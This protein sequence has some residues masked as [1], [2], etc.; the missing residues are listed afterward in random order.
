MNKSVGRNLGKLTNLVYKQTDKAIFKSK[1]KKIR[2]LNKKLGTLQRVVDEDIYK[3]ILENLN[4]PSS[5]F[6]T[7][8]GKIT[9]SKKLWDSVDKKELQSLLAKTDTLLDVKELKQ[10]AKETLKNSGVLKSMKDEYKE[11]T[12]KLNELYEKG[13]FDEETLKIFQK[14][15]KKDYNKRVN[16]AVK[17]EVNA[18]FRVD[19]NID[20]AIQD[21]YDF[22]KSYGSMLASEYPEIIELDKFIY[23]EGVK[24]YTQLYDWMRDAEDVINKALN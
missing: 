16:E 11:D 18:K 7:Q 22:I 10:E 4:L 20:N 3:D 13:E 1:Q 14:Q 5:D 21:W 8:T 23:S 19:G 6:I 24:S 15:F 2:E 12:Q 17:D 9:T